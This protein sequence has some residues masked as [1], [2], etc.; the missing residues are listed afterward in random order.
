MEKSQCPGGGY[1]HNRCP[2]GDNIKCCKSVPY[3]ETECDTEG[4]V[5]ADECGCIGEALV[6]KCPSQ[7]AA[8][9]CCV[10]EEVEIVDDCG[11][12][13]NEVN[14]RLNQRMKRFADCSSE[15]SKACAAEGGFC[16]NPATCPGNKVVHNKC[17]GGNDNKCCLSIP[18]QEAECEGQGGECGDR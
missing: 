1:S 15:T 18:Y 9:K 13:S 12:E 10:E 16:V 17:P 8:V 14:E 7:P 11:E 5:C 2:G 3:Q 4:G 6:G